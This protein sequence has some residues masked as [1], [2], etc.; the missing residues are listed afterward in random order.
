[1]FKYKDKRYLFIH[2]PKNAG[3]SFENK[4]LNGKHIG[5][6]KLTSYPSKHWN[7]SIAIV[8]NPFTRIVS[9]YNYAKM[10]KSY[11]H[12]TDNTTRY[13]LHPLFEYCNKNSF[14]EFILD[15]CCNNKFQDIIHLHE[16][17][18]FL[19]T[20]DKIIKTKIIRFENLDKELSEFFE[21]S[22]TMPKQNSSRS[23]SSTTLFD[24][25]MIE[26]VRQKYKN[27]FYYFGPYNVPS[28]LYQNRI[29]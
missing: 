9:I 20:P 5:H 18:Y 23:S 16:Q 2:V 14:K 8:R 21:D 28:E 24:D 10:E 6:H 4:F 17:Y 29:K 13:G 7:N 12:S 25:E 22:I 19:K 11:W 15:I 27:D 1:M 3:T 26:Y